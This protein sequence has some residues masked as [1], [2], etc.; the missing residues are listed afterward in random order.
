MQART[1]VACVEAAAGLEVVSSVAV[2]VAVA[3]VVVVVGASVVVASSSA[4][5]IDVVVVT[6]ASPSSV[7]AGNIVG[8]ARVAR[9]GVLTTVLCVVSTG[10]PAADEAVAAVAVSVAF[11][12]A[13]HGRS[14]LPL[15]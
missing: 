13:Q 7:V 6:K 4:P 10:M 2:A 5:G 15:T 3:V 12:A 8:L 14:Q 1:V 9:V 11:A